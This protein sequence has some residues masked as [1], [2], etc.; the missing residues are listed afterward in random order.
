MDWVLTALIVG[1]MVYAST[2]VTHFVRYTS[3]VVPQMRALEKAAE[4]RDAAAEGERVLQ[5]EIHERVEDLK[6]AV[7]ALQRDIALVQ[8]EVYSERNRKQRLEMLVFK[9]RLRASRW[10]MTA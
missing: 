2:T 3:Y 6:D 9:E 1:G 8:A 4:E 5:L 7:E 10:A